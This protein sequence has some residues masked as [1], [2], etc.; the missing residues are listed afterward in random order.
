[1]SRDEMSLWTR[2]NQPVSRQYRL[3]D[4][5]LQPH[6]Q[7]DGVYESLEAALQDAS[8]WNPRGSAPSSAL[9]VEV[10]TSSGQ[11]RTVRVPQAMP[12]EGWSA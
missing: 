1:M 7:L 4:G 12:G 6:P 9:G 8:A 11:W 2:L 5:T 10:S 3:V